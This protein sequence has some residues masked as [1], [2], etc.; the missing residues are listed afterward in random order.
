MPN[1]A[2]DPEKAWPG[3]DPGWIP[4]F[5]KSSCA[6][7]KLEPRQGRGHGPPSPPLFT[8]DFRYLRLPVR[9]EVER[10]GVAHDHRPRLQGV[11]GADLA[12]RRSHLVHHDVDDMGRPV[13]AQR[14]HAPQKRLS[15][16]R[17]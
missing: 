15:S 16:K 5:G 8:S 3:L 12:E 4:V 2:H 14:P 6:T 10:A 13:G 1:L 11:A 7:Y 17:R 9:L